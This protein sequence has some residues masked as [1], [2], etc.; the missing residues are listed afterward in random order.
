MNTMAEFFF[1][2]RLLVSNSLSFPFFR[3]RVI[4]ATVRGGR[5]HSCRCFRYVD[6]ALFMLLLLLL[7]SFK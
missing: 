2:V 4:L 6:T 1:R 3:A 7:W 5:G